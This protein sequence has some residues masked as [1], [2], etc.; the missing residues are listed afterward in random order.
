MTI[1]SS[2]R[3]F[4]F[5]ILVGDVPNSGVVAVFR[6]IG[7]C[8]GFMCGDIG[9]LVVLTF[10]WLLTTDALRIS[11]EDCNREPMLTLLSSFCI[12]IVLC[13]SSP[14]FST[15]KSLPKSKCGT[16][17]FSSAAANTT[18]RLNAWLSYECIRHRMYDQIDA[19][20]LPVRS[21]R[22][23]PVPCCSKLPQRQTHRQ[24]C[25]LLALTIV[26]LNRPRTHLDAKS[27]TSTAEFRA[28][29]LHQFI[30]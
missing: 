12:H 17:N 23:Y 29:F 24:S 28:Q 22:L 7:T 13:M 15:I 26:V 27:L 18:S 30:K 21:Y 25:A 1:V 11:L 14:S 5:G 19:H 16:W 10:D 3:I 6:G 4:S 2:T 20:L 9:G 8:V